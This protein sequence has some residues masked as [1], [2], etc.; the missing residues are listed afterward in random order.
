MPKCKVPQT[1]FTFWVGVCYPWLG[2]RFFGGEPDQRSDSVNSLR[3]FGRE[4][5]PHDVTGLMRVNMDCD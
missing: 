4:P 5:K 2:A 1:L 3:D